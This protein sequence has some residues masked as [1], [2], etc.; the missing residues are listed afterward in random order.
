MRKVLL[1]FLLLT[2]FVWPNFT[3]ADTTISGPISSDTTWSPD[4][5]VYIIDS[6]FSVPSG[7]TL[8]IEPGTIIKAKTTALGG[9]SIYGN[10]IAE[11]TSE[12]P[13][14]FTSIS[15]DSIG[16]DTGNDATTTG[17]V[18]QW[19]GLY[20]KGGSTGEL[21]HVVVRYAGQ[22]GFGFGDFIGIENDGGTL[23]IKNSLIDQNNQHGIWQ[24]A[25]VLVLENTVISNHL[26]GLTIWSG[27]TTVISNDF[28][29][30][31][32]YGLHASGGDSLNLTDNNFIDN[33]KTAYV[34]ASI[35]FSHIG[36]NS[37]D[38][39]NRGF[40]TGGEVRDEA[41]WHTSD[42][43]FIINGLTVVSG[44]TLTLSAGTVLKMNPGAYLDVRGSLISSGTA[45]TPVYLTSLKDDSVSGDTNGDGA[46]SSP[47]MTNWN[48]ITFYQSS[49]GDISNSVIRYSGG[50]N[51]TGRSA[52]FNLGGNLSLD[53]ILFSNN[54]QSDIHQN[55]GSSTISHST[56]STNTNM[57]LSNTST[58]T[59]DARMNWWG[60]DT[61]PSHSTNATGTGPIVSDNVL[62]NPWLKRDPDLPNPVIIVPGILSS[63]LINSSDSISSE[64][65]P[66]G[67]LLL[68]PFDL[69]LNALSLLEDGITSLS[70]IQVGD[71]IDSIGNTDFFLGLINTLE[72]EGYQ[73][74]IGLF[75]FPYDWRLDLKQIS[76]SLKQKIDEIKSQT[77]AEEVD[78][79]AHSMGGLVTKE[80][81]N[82]YN[83]NKINKFI[84]IGTPH[85]GSPKAFKILN[86]GDNLDATFF[87]NLIGL[88][89]ERVKIISQNMPAIY[90][91]L[92]SRN[93]FD[94]SD[95]NYK[96]YVFN[97]INLTDRLT[98]DQTKSY[99]KS[100]GR[101]NVL[102]DRADIFHQEIDDLDPADYGV[103]TYNIVGCGTPTIGQFYI[104]DNTD[105]HYKYNI[106]M[107]NGDG[108]VPLKSA[109]AIPAFKT[110]YVKNAQHALMP[111]TSGV[112]ELVAS[113]LT[114]KENFNIA[115]Y[116]NL[117][118]TADNCQIP[119]G[120]IV[121]FHSPIELHIYDQSGN[122]TGPDANGDIENNISGVVYEVIDDNRFAF[123]P[124]GVEYTVKGKATD[125]GTFDVRIQE[126]V[127]GEV[128]ATTIFSDIPLTP[129][130]QT[131][132]DVGSNIPSKIYL[133]NDRDN[134]FESSMVVSTTTAGF[135]ESTGKMEK[136][137][138]Q[139]T[140]QT[141]ND[142]ISGSG[143]SKSQS[144]R[145]QQEPKHIATSSEILVLKSVPTPGI[146]KET[147]VQ[148]K[149]PEAIE[150]PKAT[151]T[152]Q[153]TRYENTAIVYKSFGYKLTAIFKAFWAWLKSR[154]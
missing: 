107:I 86:Y 69:H 95:N 37:S 14:Y 77:G 153:D 133:D 113:I 137:V 138:V 44:E 130:T 134:V 73:K 9:P 142:S 64:V 42:L 82:N 40:E 62:F 139:T 29:S 10:L 144:I 36:N 127:N 125:T 35:S 8:T 132:F 106:K 33:A 115:P 3:F 65:W 102:V 4:G 87:F 96:Y 19:Q 47:N 66:A 26:F 141:A 6:Y 100:E 45:S 105:G 135:L 78:I 103:E 41:V 20:F 79:V 89:V 56:F 67:P 120:K 30:N 121:S 109:E 146:I 70:N 93:Y 46:V 39:A 94:D 99:L 50:F 71:P 68:F 147:K 118:L 123:L 129:N 151:S 24:R 126:M 76:V 16:G 59:L 63:K 116:S 23:T 140:V 22:G 21:D 32:Q 148:P 136:V 131:N 122:H 28:V 112:K 83:D 152:T 54:F 128:T 111:S 43:P 92:P 97:S 119:N 60:T 90:E 48:G 57:V 114:G 49:V 61:G 51:G 5:G 91:L 25:G 75:I 18:G 88:S 53:N 85:T 84:D 154:L 52:I 34:A 38:T 27:I 101:N 145:T 72:S 31:S 74:N 58:G 15:D 81:L 149:P 2:F 80:Y 117:A 124:D 12:L 143:S 108:T 110:Y 7:V 11:G 104:L 1:L 98:F 55:T 13:I 150:E 17:A